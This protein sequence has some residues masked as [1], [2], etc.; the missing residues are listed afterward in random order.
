MITSWVM[1]SPSMV[2]E[3]NC[4]RSIL[5]SMVPHRP[6]PQAGPAPP[7]ANEPPGPIL[8]SQPTPIA[9]AGRSMIQRWGWDPFRTGLE[10]AVEDAAR[11]AL[12]TPAPP[13]LGGGPPPRGGGGGGGGHG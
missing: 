7:S 11:Q 1:V 4:V 13:R 3:P 6:S 5:G 8:P 10:R 9:K 12:A 2:T